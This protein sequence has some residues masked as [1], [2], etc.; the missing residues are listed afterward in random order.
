MKKINDN[1]KVKYCTNN[2]HIFLVTAWCDNSKKENMLIDCISKLKEFN[3]PILL[4]TQ[5]PVNTY[6]QNLVDYYNFENKNEVLFF[7]NYKDIG[8]D[9]FSYSRTSNY[10]IKNYDDYNH[11]FAVMSNIKR[12]IQL[13]NILNKKIIHYVEYDCIIDTN[14]Y[15]ETFIKDIEI[16]D[17]V[18]KPVLWSIKI[19]VA[20]KLINDIPN[21][22]KDYYNLPYWSYH[23]FFSDNLP[24]YEYSYIKKYTDKIK[25]CDY[26]DNENTLNLNALHNDR[27]SV[28][29]DMKIPKIKLAVNNDNNLFIEFTKIDESLIEIKYNTFQ[30]FR[31]I[32]NHSLI[33]LDKY[34]KN[35]KI[36]INMSGINIYTKTLIDDVE[37][38]KK[39]NYIKFIK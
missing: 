28:I 32:N 4:S 29:D 31:K 15:F 18:I 9:I 35:E 30:Q 16:Y 5:Y 12:S 37:V 14:Q 25:I 3:I 2:D 38:F 39:K 36:I 7:E 13:C 24:P 22:M 21:N 26:I 11:H 27:S 33:N 8:F 34:I 10:T 19:D 23:N 20:L 17:F 1:I 6:I